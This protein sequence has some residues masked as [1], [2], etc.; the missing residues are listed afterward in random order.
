MRETKGGKCDKASLFIPQDNGKGLTYAL[1][2]TSDEA[3][4]SAPLRELNATTRETH[5]VNF[6]VS[7][8]STSPTRFTRTVEWTSPANVDD[9][10]VTVKGPSTVDVQSGATT[11]CSLTLNFVREGQY[12]GVV[13][14]K[15][16]SNSDVNQYF[17][18]LVRVTTAAASATSAALVEIR[19]PVRQ[20]ALYNIPIG[21][22]LTKPSP[23]PASWMDLP[24][25]SAPSPCQR[26]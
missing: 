25:C 24:M 26:V 1:E 23:S 4:P 11:D 9:G 16:T 20:R 15:S 22:P 6:N 5:T 21:N 10:L 8:W 2:G 13:H 12:R 3:G 17:E 19:T 18:L 7:N 14:F